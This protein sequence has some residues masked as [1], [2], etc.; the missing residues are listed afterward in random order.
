MDIRKNRPRYLAAILWILFYLVS[1]D[2]M[3]NILFS[4]PK[5]PRNITPSIIQ[6]H[7]E[8][9]RSTEGKFARM[10]RSKDEDSAPIVSSGW[11]ESNKDYFL[12]K[13]QNHSSKPVVTI[14]GM[15]HANL[16]AQDLAKYDNSISVRFIGAPGAVPSFAFKAYTIDRERLH[17]DVAI[18]VIMTQGVPAILTTSGATMFFER[19]YPYTY[20]RYFIRNGKLE[21]IPP[22]FMSVDGYREYFYDKNKWRSY[23]AWLSEY[24]KFYDPLLFRETIFDNSSLFRLLR[25]AYVKTDINAKRSTVYDSSGF[26]V[27]SEEVKILEKIVLE[28]AQYAYRDKT[29]P[30]IYIVNNLNTGDSLYRLLEP[31]L[32]SHKIIF[33]SSHTV[34]PPN[35]PRSYLPDSHFEPSKNMILAGIMSKMIHDG[36]GEG[37]LN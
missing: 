6:Q 7:F 22:P 28:F 12:S 26:N 20:P 14:Y 24:D 19:S 37:C 36:L 11:L 34:C 23:V 4:Y 15:S 3:I 35:D 16:L 18:L 8:Y 5:D 9:G 10:T 2:I 32:S 27:N 17:S 31:V 1:I 25:R 21:H 33:L 29:L 30:I 13:N